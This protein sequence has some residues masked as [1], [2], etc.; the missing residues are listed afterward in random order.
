M[1][2]IFSELKT[3]NLVLF[4]TKVKFIAPKNLSC[5]PLS[6][7]QFCSYYHSETV[8]NSVVSRLATPMY[9]KPE[10]L[11]ALLVNKAFVQTKQM[12]SKSCSNVGYEHYLWLQFLELDAISVWLYSVKKKYC[13]LN[14]SDGD[15]L[16]ERV[17]LPAFHE[18][19]TNIFVP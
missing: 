9:S 6:R 4:T 11:C 14:S 7:T 8:I 15:L 18:Y 5:L 13:N 17:S 16:L 2:I 12:P 3:S 1:C 10:T 19:K